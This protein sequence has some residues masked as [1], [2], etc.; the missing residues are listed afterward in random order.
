MSITHRKAT[1]FFYKTQKDYYIY[2]SKRNSYDFLQRIHH[3]GLATEEKIR[4]SCVS[5]RLRR[6]LALKVPLNHM[7]SVR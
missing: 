2:H 6:A 4:F 7:D 1:S 3:T 5:S